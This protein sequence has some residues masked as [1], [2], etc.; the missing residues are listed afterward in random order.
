MFEVTSGSKIIL[1]NSIVHDNYAIQVPIG[2]VLE[3]VDASE[4][5]KTEI[6]E[7][8]YVSTEEV[9]QEV[10]GN[11]SKLCMI[12]QEL[13]KYLSNLLPDHFR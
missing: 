2:S 6:Y 12:S 4:L 13:K 1:A 5:A 3:T 11:C 7:N 8:Y 9:L 10:L